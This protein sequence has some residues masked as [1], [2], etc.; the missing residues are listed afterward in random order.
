[1]TAAEIVYQVCASGAT[2]TVA[3][4]SLELTAPRPLT[5]ELLRRV[6]A[7]KPEI[8]K[9][10]RRQDTEAE[11]L[12]EYF[13]ER[14]GILEY[15]GG[16]PRAEAEREAAR[17]TATYARNQDYLW[18]ALRSA[19][20]GYPELLAALPERT[21]TVDSLPLGVAKVAVFIKDRKVLQQGVCE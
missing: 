10:L 11:D 7:H 20:S 16:L 14:A 12:R 1:M 6:A 4:D 3:G 13:E 2:I 9:I 21:G 8:M 18:A 5:D 17:I 19:L 15:D